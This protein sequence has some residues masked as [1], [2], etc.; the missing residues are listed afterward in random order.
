MCSRTFPWVIACYQATASWCNCVSGSLLNNRSNTCLSGNGLRSICCLLA[1]HELHSKHKFSVEQEPRDTFHPSPR[2]VSR[3]TFRDKFLGLVLQVGKPRKAFSSN[4]SSSHSFTFWLS[5]STRP[6]EEHPFDT[7]VNAKYARTSLLCRGSASYSTPQPLQRK[8]FVR[9]TFYVQSNPDVVPQFVFMCTY[10]SLLF[11]KRRGLFSAFKRTQKNIIRSQSSSEQLKVKSSL[12]T[13]HAKSRSSCLN[14]TGVPRLH[15]K[16]L[17][18]E[19]ACI[20][21][22]SQARAAGRKP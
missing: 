21:N 16:S 6:F 8:V 5:D 11:I 14:A 3:L 7:S 12:W 20:H 22:C 15:L 17:V 18:L 1:L 13:T 19:P 9:C 2:N 10:R 4:S